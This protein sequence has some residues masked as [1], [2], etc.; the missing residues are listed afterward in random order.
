MRITAYK[1]DDGTIFVNRAEWLARQSWLDLLKAID[2]ADGCDAAN[3][4]AGE[5]AAFLVHHNK[6]IASLIRKAVDPHNR[7]VPDW[8]E[9]EPDADAGGDA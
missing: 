1:A 5:V 6:R 8:P 3:E 7:T 2:R 4:A 9:A